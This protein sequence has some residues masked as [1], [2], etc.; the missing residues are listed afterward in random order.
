MSVHLFDVVRP[1]GS[2]GPVGVDPNFCFRTCFWTRATLLSRISLS[3]EEGQVGIWTRDF[4]FFR[5]EVDRSVDCCSSPAFCFRLHSSIKGHTDTNAA[6]PN[7]IKDLRTV[8]KTSFPYIFEEN[9]TVPLKVADGLIRCNV[10]RPKG[11]E[12][13]PVLVTYGPYGKDIHYK[14]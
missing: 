8:D 9:V 13:V 5:I 10:Y 4:P 3:H 6:M 7:E 1:S 11:S 12:P 2:T 14:E